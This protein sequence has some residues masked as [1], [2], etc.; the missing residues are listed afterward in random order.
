MIE[1]P[2]DIL[3]LQSLLSEVLLRVVALEEENVLLKR[4]NLELQKENK[5]LKRR[6]GMNSKNSHTPQSSE[7]YKKSPALIK[8]SEVL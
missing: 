7:G 6:L 4:E 2:N 5:E 8:M 1:I 3:T